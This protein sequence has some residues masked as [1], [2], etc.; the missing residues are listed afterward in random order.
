MINIRS[1]ALSFVAQKAVNYYIKNNYDCEIAIDRFDVDISDGRA[2]A[3]IQF[4]MSEEDLRKII[5][6]IIS[7]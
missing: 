5:E 3:S 7:S 6:K 1:K 2:G 4:N